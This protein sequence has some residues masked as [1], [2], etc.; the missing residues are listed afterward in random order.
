MNRLTPPPGYKTGFCPSAQTE[1]A[2][3]S[4]TPLYVENGQAVLL[5]PPLGQ[6]PVSQAEPL[7]TRSCG[8]SLTTNTDCSSALFTQ[9]KDVLP[10]DIRDIFESC[11]ISSQQIACYTNY[12][13]ALL[14]DYPPESHRLVMFGAQNVLLSGV[15]AT[16]MPQEKIRE[17]FRQLPLKRLLEYYFKVNK[18]T[19]KPEKDKN[20]GKAIFQKVMVKAIKAVAGH[21]DEKQII[22]V[23]VLSWGLTASHVTSIMLEAQEI[24]GIKYGFDYLIPGPDNFYTRQEIPEIEGVIRL[25][26]DEELE[27]HA[28]KND[29]L[30]RLMS[31]NPSLS[32]DLMEPS[33]QH[34]INEDWP[35]FELNPQFSYLVAWLNQRL[36]ET[37]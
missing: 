2:G 16:M 6:R 17:Y 9:K 7:L 27:K 22:L 12:A 20:Q 26:F 11:C 1:Q 36:A 35:G 28:L 18:E 24:A 10:A 32:V 25:R 19:E 23:R 3:V 4:Q 31:F 34:P 29:Q 21:A 37:F 8:S 5:S 15:L 13:K 14:R 30:T 33:V